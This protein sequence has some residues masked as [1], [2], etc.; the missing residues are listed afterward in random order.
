MDQNKDGT[1]DKTEYFSFYELFIEPFEET[2]DT[3]GTYLL[4][5]DE[6]KKCIE[7]LEEFQQLSKV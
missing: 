3:S 1:V 2:C 4:S 7:S 5:S 6:I